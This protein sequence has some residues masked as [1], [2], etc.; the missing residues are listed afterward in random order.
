MCLPDLIVCHLASVLSSDEV[1][2][3]LIGVVNEAFVDVLE[4]LLCLVSLVVGGCQRA[5]NLALL[6]LEVLDGIN[7][8]DFCLQV[9]QLLV[10]PA[11][12]FINDFEDAFVVNFLGPPI[13]GLAEVSLVEEG[14]C[15]VI[16]LFVKV[17]EV[18]RGNFLNLCQCFVVQQR[19]VLLHIFVRDCLC[20]VLLRRS[21]DVLD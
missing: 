4:L 16:E 5:I 11:I 13:E 12:H 17:I 8:V 9:I 2:Y 10:T 3:E 14:I 7:Q 6:L 18:A 21:N 1:L 19:V 20:C 15:I